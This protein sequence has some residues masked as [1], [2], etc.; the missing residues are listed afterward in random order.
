MRKV[1]L[2]VDL[3]TITVFIQDWEAVQDMEMSEKLLNSHI[4]IRI[5]KQ[6]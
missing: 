4:K 3:M 5:T 1:F 2:L 6:N